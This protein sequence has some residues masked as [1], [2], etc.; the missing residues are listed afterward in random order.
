VVE[1]IQS[2]YYK[3]KLKRNSKIHTIRMRDDTDLVEDACDEQL[4][5]RLKS[6]ALRFVTRSRRLAEMD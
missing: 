6:E 3:S 4:C 5:F 1:E 2:T